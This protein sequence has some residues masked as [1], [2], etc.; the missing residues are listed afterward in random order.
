MQFSHSRV[1]CFEKCK[2]QFKLRYI[3]GIR[4]IPMYGA[5]SALIVGSAMHIGIEE[6]IDKMERFYYN[7]YPVITD[8]NIN[9]VIKLSNLVNKAKEALNS[10]L[11]NKEPTVIYEY[12]IDF[13]EFI[14]FVDLIIKNKDETISVYD[15]KYSNNKEHYLKSK[16][17]HL[18]KYFLEKLGF[19]VTDLGYIFIAKTLI[20]QKKTE[21]LYQFRKRLKET[22]ENMEVE[23]VNI[24]YDEIKVNE[25]FRICD[26]IKNETEFEKTPSKLC[27]WCE[28]KLYCEGGET[29]MLL[30]ENKR[31]DIKIDENPDMWI[32]ADSYVGKST[33]VDKFPNLIFL[34]TDGNTDNTTSPVVKIADEV[35]FE[36]R[37]KK[38][39]WLG[40]YFLM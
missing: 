15:F 4:T 1:E 38:Q 33:F 30:P 32:Y 10:I 17:L 27:E 5:D 20:R 39:K 8:E 9:E 28:Y 24:D 40:K 18:Y 2:Y 6:G 3:D 26:E 31:R 35:T 11:H 22:L 19:K 23:I 14:G 34:N 37:L 21:D 7:Q 12:K 36:G 16:Q 13:P 29:Y 25:F